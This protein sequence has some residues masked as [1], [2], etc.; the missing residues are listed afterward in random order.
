MRIGLTAG[1]SARTDGE[2][3]WEYERCRATQD[4][5]RHLLSRAGHLVILPP[6]HVFELSNDAALMAKI[7]HFNAKQVDM[8]IEL[9]LNAG[10]GRY[11]TAIYWDQGKRHSKRG[12]QLASALCQQ[13]TAGL[14]WKTIGAR[15]MSYFARDLAFLRDTDMPSVITEPA[16]D[17]LRR[18]HD[19]A[20]MGLRRWDRRGFASLLDGA[21]F[22]VE[23]LTGFTALLV[24]VVLAR[25]AWERLRGVPDGDEIADLAPPGAWI[26]G[27]RDFLL[28]P[29]WNRILRDPRWGVGLPAHSGRRT[30]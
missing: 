18:A 13:F 29:G 3:H 6:I 11:S 26:G 30:A 16:F 17:W 20:D 14:P 27:G 9:H 10:A 8:A 24:P 19:D 12:Q 2:R 5:I 25:V 22:A 21:G 15:P 1:H 23:R 4:H 7:R 28:E